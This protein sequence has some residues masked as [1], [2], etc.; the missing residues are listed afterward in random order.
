MGMPITSDAVSQITKV[1]PLTVKHEQ[2]VWQALLGGFLSG[3]TALPTRMGLDGQTFEQLKREMIDA[4]AF[5]TTAQQSQLYAQTQQLF[6]E[7]ID[8][9]HQERDDLYHLLLEYADTDLRW[10]QQVAWVVANASMSAYH[11]WQSL[12]LDERPILSRLIGFY[13]PRL[14]AGNVNNMRWKRYFYKQLCERGGDYLCKAPN[15]AQCTS[16]KECF[17]DAAP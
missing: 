13:F 2:Q 16:Y 15:C 17:I 11:L 10:H 9:R 3:R 4:Q 6:A 5:T 1:N 12:G 8:A 7:L 14:H